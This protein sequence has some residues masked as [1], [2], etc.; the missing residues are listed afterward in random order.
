MK[1]RKLFTRKKTKPSA[2]MALQITSMADVFTILLVFL[3]KG[4]ASDVLQITPANATRLPSSA[5]TKSIT[6]NAIQIEITNTEVMVEKDP[7]GT[8]DHFNEQ[9]NERLKIERKKQELISKSNES[10]KNDARA[11]VIADEKTPYQTIKTVLRSLSANGY[12][13]INFAVMQE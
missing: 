9:L 2:E 12:S 7:I 4:L 1:T 5:L 3:L 10:V 13:E 8:L 6:E 11:I